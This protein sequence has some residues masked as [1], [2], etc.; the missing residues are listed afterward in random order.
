ML[1]LR[2]LQKYTFSNISWV[3]ELI[4]ANHYI[5]FSIIIL[6][7]NRK[8]LLF[9]VFKFGIEISYFFINNSFSNFNKGGIFKLSLYY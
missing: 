4:I 2:C 9:I 3:L 1:L 7:G 6:T 5:F 8:D